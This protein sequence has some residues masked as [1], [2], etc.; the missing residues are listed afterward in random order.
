MHKE[1]ADDVEFFI[2][3]IR[4]AHPTDGRQSQA[5]V[6]EGILIEQPKSFDDR[7]KV[8][9]EMC[10]KLEI[11]IPAVI[12]GIDDKVNKD[13]SALPDRLYLVGKDGKIAYKGERGPRGFMPEE[14]QTAIEKALGKSHRLQGE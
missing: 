3:Y 12:D 1:F 11:D 6:R 14:L 2:V 5:N 9:T 8:A 13:Y 7:L 4:E 10:S